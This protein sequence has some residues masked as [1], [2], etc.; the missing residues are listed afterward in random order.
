LDL[1]TVFVASDPA[2]LAHYGEVL[3]NGREIAADL[4][5]K[6]TDTG[7]SLGEGLGDSKSGGMREGLDNGDAV[8]YLHIH[9]LVKMPNTFVL[10]KRKI[11]PSGDKR[12][13]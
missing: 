6:F 11:P 13:L 7:S 5:M 4:L 8:D 10:S 1:Q 3:G 2:G 12:D 9:Y